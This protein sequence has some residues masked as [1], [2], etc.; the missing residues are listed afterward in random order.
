[1]AI[2]AEE[3]R[4]AIDELHAFQ[5]ASEAALADLQSQNADIRSQNAHLA[6]AHEQSHHELINLRTIVAQGGGA[7]P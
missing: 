1:M 6:A 2:S 4:R 7:R 5:V 3:A